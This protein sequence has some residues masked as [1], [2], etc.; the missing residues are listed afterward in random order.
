MDRFLVE[1]LLPLVNDKGDMDSLVAYANYRLNLVYKNIEK[2]T[3][4]R[5]LGIAQGQ[6]AELNALIKLRDTVQGR[7]KDY[8]GS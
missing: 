8:A 1:N 7:A 3:D 4:P 6:I 5:E 2:I